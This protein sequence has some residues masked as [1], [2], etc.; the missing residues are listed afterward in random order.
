MAARHVCSTATS[1]PPDRRGRLRNGAT[2]GD[3]L[4]APRCGAHT[5]SG[6][7][8]RQPAMKNGR[9]RMH[10]G[11]S[12]GP[13]T[14]EGRA[15]CAAARRTHGFYSAEMV[16]LRRA[17]TAYCRRMDALFSS[18]KIR[19]TAGHGVLP[20]KS[21]KAAVGATPSGRPSGRRHGRP[22]GGVHTA[23]AAGH[24]LLPP[25]L[26][27]RTTGRADTPPSSTTTAARSAS[28]APLRLRGESSNAHSTSTAGH[29]VLPPVSA[30]SLDSV[31]SL[32]Q[33]T[34]HQGFVQRTLLGGTALG[35]GVTVKPPVPAL[36]QRIP[37]PTASLECFNSKRRS[38]SA[39]KPR[40][41]R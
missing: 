25:K 17:G 28:S 22:H 2:P 19:R 39:G 33:P 41:W 36:G 8:C 27:N 10:G 15:R 18:L 16:A 30:R 20:R 38:R 35:L 1:L 7:C 9:C 26:S 5:R 29:G 12:T 3:F 24:G 14:T 32:G 37:L 31:R 23:A 40:A 21:H 13:R 34:I 4:A 6:G 11:L